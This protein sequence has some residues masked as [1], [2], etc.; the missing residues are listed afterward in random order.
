MRR[1]ELGLSVP[2]QE[3]RTRIGAEDEPSVQLAHVQGLLPDPIT[4]DQ[5]PCAPHV[6]DC[7]GE[8]PVQ[9]R[10]QVIP[11]LLVTVHDDLGVAP[12]PEPVPA[13]LELFPELEV[14]PDLTVVHRYDAVVFVRHRLGAPGHVDDAE[15]GVA[16]HAMRLD[17]NRASIRPAVAER[18]DRRRDPIAICLLD[19]TRANHA[20]DAA[21]Q[22][23]TT[24]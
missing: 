10:R 6:P 20:D 9:A 7:E 4:G 15:P 13:L 23:S 18:Y 24:G 11:P 3:H 19:A 2:G 21:H 14:V 22:S 1:I 17:A 5:E 12:G 16:E 8:H